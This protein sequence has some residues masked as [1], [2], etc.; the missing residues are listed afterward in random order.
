[1]VPL[2]VDMASQ[3]QLDSFD[4]ADTLLVTSMGM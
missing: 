2:R 1:M 4:T 3:T